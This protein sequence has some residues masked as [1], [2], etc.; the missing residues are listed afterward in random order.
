[1]SLL[2]TER[3]SVRKLKEHILLSSELTGKSSPTLGDIVGPTE[4]MFDVILCL[5]KQHFITFYKFKLLE[6]IVEIVCID[7]D[8]KLKAKLA[9]YKKQFKMY[10]RRR[11]C[12]SSLYYGARFNPEDACTPK[13][14]CN[15]VLITD[16]RWDHNAT[17]EVLLDLECEVADIFGIKRF[18]LRLEAITK[19]CLRLYYS[20]PANVEHVIL[21]IQHEQVL[22][23][24]NCGIAEIHCGGHHMFL[25]IM[26][27]C[28]YL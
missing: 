11:V 19:N 3:T 13:E 17:L 14:G 25:Q 24:M 1:M 21:S 15:L 6:S 20:I 4:S 16:E 7:K 22:K 5:V 8:G 2:E 12:E 23:L 10:I 27:K 26:C 9:E 18:L 28:M